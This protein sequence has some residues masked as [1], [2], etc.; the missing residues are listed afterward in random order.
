MSEVEN[1]I[2]VFAVKSIS[3]SIEW[4]ALIFKFKV[5]WKSD[6]ICSISRDDHCLMLNEQHD[7]SSPSMA[8]I[9][10]EFESIFDACLKNNV[11]ITKQPTNEDYAYNMKVKDPDGNILWLGS[12]PK[13]TD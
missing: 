1:V 6:S 3:T 11:E 2:P 4:Y 13:S 10:V 7:L 5:D 12:E 9:G 8:W